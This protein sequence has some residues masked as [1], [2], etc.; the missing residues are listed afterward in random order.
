[1]DTKIARYKFKLEDATGSPTGDFA[2]GKDFNMMMVELHDDGSCTVKTCNHRGDTKVY[3]SEPD[4]MFEPARGPGLSR[5]TPVQRDEKAPEMVNH[6]K[7]YG[8]KDN[9]YETIKVLEAWLP[10]EQFIGFLRGTSIKYLSRFGNK[11]AAEQEAKKA[12]W[13]DDYLADYLRRVS[14]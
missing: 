12:A 11:D 2:P 3:S 8:G 9:Q 10:R 1:M 5:T 6:P 7:H 4:H 14:K 13:Y